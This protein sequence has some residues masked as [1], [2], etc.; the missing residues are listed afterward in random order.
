M[1][2]E[3]FAIRNM[4]NWDLVNSFLTSVWFERLSYEQ[5][6]R[7]G[8]AYNNAYDRLVAQRDAI[9]D[10]LMKRLGEPQV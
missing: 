6:R 5:S 4:S 10:E 2:D 9:R 3:R 1:T 7:S 8:S